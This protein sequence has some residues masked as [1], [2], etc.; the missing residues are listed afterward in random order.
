[1]AH[2]LQSSWAGPFYM[3]EGLRFIFHLFSFRHSHLCLFIVTVT[4]TVFIV[5]LKG[6]VDVVVGIYM[7]ST[8]SLRSSRALFLT[9][10]YLV[11]YTYASPVASIPAAATWGQYSHPPQPTEWEQD[12]SSD[13]SSSDFPVLSAL[14]N[15]ISFPFNNWVLFLCTAGPCL[16]LLGIVIHLNRARRSLLA[17]KLD[18]ETRQARIQ[19]IE[20]QRIDEMESEMRELAK[21]G[22]DPT[23]VRRIE[24]GVYRELDEDDSDY[25][26]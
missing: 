19:Q 7:A 22:V 16:L 13:N 10:T 17:D 15:I 21:L 6:D 26:D 11:T 25:Y 12:E 23:R 9:L 5:L 20:Q 18:M 8:F 4:A 24:P 2:L 14:Y 1:M 3:N